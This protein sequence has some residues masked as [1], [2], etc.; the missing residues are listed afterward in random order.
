VR[1][2]S[3]FIFGSALS[4]ASAISFPDRFPDANT[5]SITLCSASAF[6]SNRLYRIRLSAVNR[7]HFLSNFGQPQFVGR[8]AGE[9][10]Q[11]AFMLDTEPRKHG[12]D[13]FGV[14]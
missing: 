4:S 9:M 3:R 2:A 6:F 13:R 11:V 14:T 8:P 12:Q 7:A 10:T 1:A 5:N